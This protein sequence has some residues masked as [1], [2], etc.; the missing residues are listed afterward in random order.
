MANIIVCDMCGKRLNQ[1]DHC[2]VITK[3]VSR[4]PN[5]FSQCVYHSFC[6]ECLNTIRESIRTYRS[7]RFGCTVPHITVLLDE[8]IDPYGDY[9]VKE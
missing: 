5:V 7:K 6:T 2:D 4:D 8:F 3:Y 1:T 9:D